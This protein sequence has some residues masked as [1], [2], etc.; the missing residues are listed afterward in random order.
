[1]P[2][3][4][5]M[6]H[7]VRPIAGGAYPKLRGLEPSQF[8]GQLDYFKRHYSV[9]DVQTLL[10][11]VQMRRELPARPLLLTFDDGYIDHAIYARPELDRRGIK[12]AFFPI[13][14]AALDRRVMR[15]NKIQFVLAIAPDLKK[16][17]AKIEGVADEARRG[18]DAPSAA[19]FREKYYRATRLD[20]ATTIYIKRMLQVGLPE[21]LRNEI[22]DEL[23]NTYITTDESAFADQLYM[24]AS[25]LRSLTNAGHHI[26]CHTE[27]H[28]W[29]GSL[30]EAAQR[31]EIVLAL[32]LHDRIGITRENF[33][34][35]YPYGDFNEGLL[36]VL[37]QLGCAAAFGTRVDLVSSAQNEALTLPRLDTVDFPMH[38]DAVPNK[39]TLRASQQV[40]SVGI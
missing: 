23:F 9:I 26:G 18:Y 22:I 21:T 30:D 38:A 16:L 4:V 25:D 32:R 6:Y 1:M 8:I 35:C 19:Y 27:N 24:S 40:T 31:L 13:S 10:D 33:T 7:Y 28:P 2:L 17:M 14:A 12:G 39:W 3:T 34:F 15:M 20:D 36:S 29:M 11:H 5:V 37:K